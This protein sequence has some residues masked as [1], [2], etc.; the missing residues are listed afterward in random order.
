MVGDE[1]QLKIGW[2][3]GVHCARMAGMYT[4]ADVFER[5]RANRW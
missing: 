5:R 3:L 2:L 1:G 4:Q